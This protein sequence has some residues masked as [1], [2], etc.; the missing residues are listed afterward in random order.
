MPCQDLSIMGSRLGIEDYLVY[1]TTCYYYFYAVILLVL[2]IIIAFV[3][4]HREKEEQP[5]ADLISNLGVGSTA[6]M[7]LAV[8]G[9]LI[10]ST[11]GI[12][13]IQQD[14]LLTIVAIWIVIAA[15][16]F[17]KK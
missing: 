16:W 15:I 14:I 9:S 12:P 7:V 4:Y 17:F 6:V 2:F 3:V 10:T 11:N 1:P 5:Q 8:I 13:M